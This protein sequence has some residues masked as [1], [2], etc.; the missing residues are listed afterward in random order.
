MNDKEIRFY[1]ALIYIGVAVSALLLIIDYKLKH[2]VVEALKEG[3]PI[4]TR[5]D[6]QGSNW[7]TVRF[8]NNGVRPVPDTRFAPRMEERS[9]NSQDSDGAETPGE[10]AYGNDSPGIQGPGIEMGP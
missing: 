5:P 3:S 2:D 7:D 1:V 9:A 4:G 6:H 8:D 10:L